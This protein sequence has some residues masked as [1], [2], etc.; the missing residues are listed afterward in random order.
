MNKVIK[1]LIRTASNLQDYEEIFYQVQESIECIEKNIRTLFSG[2]N[3]IPI[4]SIVEEIKYA[5]KD[6]S[7]SESEKDSLQT[8]K[9][10][11][12]NFNKEMQSC[13]DLY[14]QLDFIKKYISTIQ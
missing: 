9:E 12:D 8:Q 7:L 2:F 11:F 14:S 4:S 6:D 10:L 3:K 1:R 5:L 13:N